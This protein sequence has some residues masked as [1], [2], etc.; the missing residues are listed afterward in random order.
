MNVVTKCRRVCSPSLTMSM[1]ASSWSRR[2][3]RTAS[4]LPSAS[5]SPSSCH[6]A[7]S[8]L[9][10][11]S[12][13]GLGRLPAI[14]VCRSL[15]IGVGVAAPRRGNDRSSG[16]PII[17]FAAPRRADDWP[18]HLTI[19]GASTYRASRSS[20][21]RPAAVRS[22]CPRSSSPTTIFPTSRT[23]ARSSPPR[24][25]SSSSRTVQDRGRGDRRG[26]R[27][28]AASCCSTRRSPSA[29]SRRCRS[30]AS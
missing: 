12:Q 25:S 28:R 10:V 21:R 1:P 23:S 20:P 2:T 18:D 4:R 24:A 5:A 15:V 30:S 8:S 27:L 7:H 26:P 13:D 3:S 29:S 16:A 11:A 9:G 14:V 6:G 19:G 17:A 22:R